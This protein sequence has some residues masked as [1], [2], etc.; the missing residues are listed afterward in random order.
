MQPLDPHP[1][2]ILDRDGIINEDSPYYI[3]SVDEFILLP[4]SV[5]AIAKLTAAG[6]R[7]G[8]AT[9]QSGVSRGYYDETKLAAIHA[10]MLYHVRTAGGRIDEIAYCVHLPEEGCRCR[11]PNPGML[12]DLATRFACETHEMIFIGD[13]ITDIQAAEAAGAKPILVRSPMTDEHAL[14]RYPHVPVFDSLAACVDH[15]IG[16]QEYLCES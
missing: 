15:L 10:K 5:Q 6:F 8:V 2:I 4:G 16:N 13:K 11:K 14:Q 3:K 9:N 12:H 1:V 7:I